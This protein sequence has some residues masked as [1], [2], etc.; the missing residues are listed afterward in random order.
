MTRNDKHDAIA[1]QDTTGR[2]VVGLFARRRDADAAIRDLNAAGF[3]DDQ[4]GVALQNR[5]EQG[6]LLEPPRAK[7]AEAAAAGAVSGG[8][9]GG[10]IG[11][12]GSLLVP[13]VG[14]VLVGGVLAS[15]LTGAGIGAAT[16]GIIGALMGL[17]VP[18][19]DA[20]HFDQG[21]RLGSTLVTVDAGPRTAEALMILDRHGMDFG[22]SGT[23]R[24]AAFDRAAGTAGDPTM[25]GLDIGSTGIGSG[26]VASGSSTGS[27]GF[28][29]RPPVAR[30][31]RARQDPGYAGP[32]RRVTVGR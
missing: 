15:M 32:E 11:L 23:E 13:G 1:A 17:G 30:E 20:H 28:E 2:T 24:F 12:L 31:R 10:L 14:P 3:T 26:D 25:A 27:R 22:P 19:A 9:V 7:E 6:D 21:L 4:V 18:E 5:E 16:G 8:L 29:P